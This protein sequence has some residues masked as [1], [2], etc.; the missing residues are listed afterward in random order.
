MSGVRVESEIVGPRSGG[1]NQDPNT[2]RTVER[3]GSASRVIVEVVE[4][5]SRVCQK[6]CSGNLTSLLIEILRDV[7]V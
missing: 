2:S 4:E 7:G 3:S 5:A 1:V 6:R